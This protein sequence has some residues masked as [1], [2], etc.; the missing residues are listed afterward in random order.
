MKQATKR[1]TLR[2]K[3]SPEHQKNK[4]QSSH[5]IPLGDAASSQ[6]LSLGDAFSSDPKATYPAHMEVDEEVVEKNKHVAPSKMLFQPFLNILQHSYNNDK[7]SKGNKSAFLKA[8]DNMLKNKSNKEIKDK[9]TE[10]F[11]RIYKEDIY[12]KEQ[13]CFL[14]IFI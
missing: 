8:R 4:A 9:A 13:N 14:I 1:E 7:L 2:E 6:H 10:E 11:K 12:N 3:A 5:Y